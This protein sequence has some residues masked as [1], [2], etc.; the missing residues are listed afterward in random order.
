MLRF[1][2]VGSVFFAILTSGVDEA[3]YERK[4]PPLTT[5]AA[6]KEQAEEGTLRNRE[7]AEFIVY[8][9]TSEPQGLSTHLQPDRRC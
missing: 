6:A 8:Q 3:N 7:N 1:F 9:S 2:F 4:T 5:T